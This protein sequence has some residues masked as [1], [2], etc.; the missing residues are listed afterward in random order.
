MRGLYSCAT[1]ARK[2]YV[3]QGATGQI[4]APEGG[5]GVEE[6]INAIRVR[7]KG[8]THE[9]RGKERATQGNSV[10]G[11]EERPGEGRGLGARSCARVSAY[12]ARGP[13]YCKPHMPGTRQHSIFQHAL[14]KCAAARA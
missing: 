11:K 13:C 7:S 4:L 12:A 5:S 2:E 9:L 10:G 1:A 14:A 3:P 8:I 6:R